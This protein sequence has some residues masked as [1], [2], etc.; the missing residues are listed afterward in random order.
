MV[1]PILSSF[2][3]PPSASRSVPPDPPDP[4]ESTR[5]AGPAARLAAVPGGDASPDPVGPDRPEP[6]ATP[7]ATMSSVGAAAT[8]LSAQRTVGDVFGQLTSE[9]VTLIDCR[10]AAVLRRDGDHWFPAAGG[11]DTGRRSGQLHAQ[12]L[13]SQLRAEHPVDPGAS[14]PRE[15]REVVAAVDPVELTS[16]LGQLG[17][18]WIVTVPLFRSGHEFGVLAVYL[19]RRGPAGEGSPAAVAE[20]LGQQAVIAL[21]AAMER[22]QLMRALESRHRVGLAQGILMA[23]LGLDVDQSFALLRDW[24]QHAN[25]KL[26]VV[27]EQVILAPDGLT[28][29]PTELGRGQR[30]GRR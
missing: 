5:P 15:P 27:A 26:R 10:A 28:H 6:S 1:Q 21:G 24:S 23:R 13:T 16:A 19:D 22:Q 20:L 4:P 18:R 2:S 17:H 14:P 29:P 7:T 30:R 12:L 3:Y 25:V 9:V 8:R 11:G